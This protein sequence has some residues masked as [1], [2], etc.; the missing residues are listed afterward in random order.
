[1]SSGPA[2]PGVSRAPARAPRG[3]LRSYA[4]GL[5]AGYAGMFVVLHTRLPQ[6]APGLLEFMP[7]YARATRAIDPIGHLAAA[8]GVPAGPL[9]QVIFIALA[10]ATVLVYWRA[11]LAVGRDHEGVTLR[12][13]LGWAAAFS[14]PLVLLPNIL[15]IDAYL[16]SLFARV[17]TIYHANPLRDA[18]LPYAHDPFWL[19][20]H[21]NWLAWPAPYGPLW[22]HVS[23]AL[24]LLADRAGGAAWQYLLA[25]KLVALGFHLLG[26][27]LLWQV[28]A[29]AGSAR[30]AWGTVFYVWNPLALVE[31]A[32]S[33]HNDSLIVAA[34]FAS[35][36]CAQRGRWRFAVLALAVGTMIKYVPVLALAAYALLVVAE[37]KAW[38]ARASR[39]LQIGGIVAATVVAC[40]ARYWD[41][42]A[43]LAGLFAYEASSVSV[44][45]VS[46][47]AQKA[48]AIWSRHAGGDYAATYATVG[49]AWGWISRAILL[50]AMTALGVR[51]W[52]RPTLE[53]LV[54][55]LFW[56]LLTVLLVRPEFW[57][58]YTTW[59]LALAALLPWGFAGRIILTFS[60][61]AFA[62]NT[63]MVG[64]QV[65]VFGPVLVLLGRAG[66][67]ALRAR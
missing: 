18:P 58:W 40:Y 4:L 56:V 50:A 67:R 3:P 27:V 15:S 43:G 42:H 46:H 33:A 37:S 39:A 55:G 36:W 20:G 63:N 41:A 59:C 47:V 25:F 22:L 64:T 19:L 31:F 17:D 44:N 45:S 2:V 52:R 66:L 8:L 1:M 29:P 35:L 28:L 21:S 5:L 14:V 11:L 32:G 30:Q 38:R 62:L 57:P 53:V 13:I 34:V 48:L 23:S 12:G 16:Y 26:G 7:A 65:V 9:A 61:C 49:Q 60:T 24:A 54:P 6:G 10:L 51:I